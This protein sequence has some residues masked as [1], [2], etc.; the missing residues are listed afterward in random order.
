MK[1]AHFYSIGSWRGRSETNGKIPMKN[2]WP[3]LSLLLVVGAVVLLF[4]GFVVSGALSP[5]DLL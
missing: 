4:V 2:A 1:T 3:L 5:L